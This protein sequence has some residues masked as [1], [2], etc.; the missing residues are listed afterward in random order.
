M[1]IQ[2]FTR[3]RKNQIGVQTAFA[4]NTGATRR[5]PYR[6][7]IEY[8]PKRETPDVDTGS[9]DPTLAA[10]LGA[11]ETTQS[12]EGKAAFNDLPY[13]YSLAIKGGVTPT[14][15]ATGR[16][17]TYQ[18]ASLTADTFDYATMQNTDDVTSDSIVAGGGVINTLGLSFGDDLGALDVSAG[19]IYARASFGDG[20]TG[21]LTVD[22]SP[23]WLYGAHT[24]VYMDTV[25]GS[26]GL[27]PIVDAIHGMEWNL[28]NNLDQKRFA[29]G[30]NAGFTLAGYGRGPREI[31]LILTLAK[32]AATVAEAQTLDDS[33]VP[34]RYFDVVTTSTEM[35]AGGATPF[36]NSIRMPGELVSREDSEINNNTV[37]RL[38]YRAKYDSTLGYAIR[39]TVTNE[40]AAL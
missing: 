26:I 32:T 23:N 22:E 30:S 34:V 1:P 33:P 38:T 18:A 3:F 35:V 6:G 14:G 36:R 20:I 15:S 16:I 19:L 12:L 39:A 27:T 11:A 2:G 5:L 28:N 25:P 17:W 29:N 10:Y 13:L 31:E 4:S 40:L 7:V 37:I 24:V 8:D 9:L 21:G